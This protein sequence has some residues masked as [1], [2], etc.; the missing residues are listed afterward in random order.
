MPAGCVLDLYSEAL[1]RALPAY[2]TGVEA[3]E[4]SL[5]LKKILLTRRWH[6]NVCAMKVISSYESWVKL[7]KN[8]HKSCQGER[9]ILIAQNGVALGKIKKLKYDGYLFCTISRA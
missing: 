8:L 3:N 2:L 5:K 9:L 4:I 6:V 7:F 1:I